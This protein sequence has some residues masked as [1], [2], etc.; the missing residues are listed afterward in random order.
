MSSISQTPSV[1]AIRHIAS[2][3]VYVGSAINPRV[4]WSQHVVALRRG[5]HH[6]KYLQRTWDKYGKDAFVFEILEPV[7]FVEDLITREQYWID[8]ARA[9]EGKYGFNV[10]PTA[11]STLG[12][13]RTDPAYLARLSKRIKDQFADPVYRAKHAKAQKARYADPVQR[14]KLLAQANEYVTS[15]DAR[16]KASERTKIQFSDPEARA[17]AAARTKVQFSDPTARARAAERSRK[18]FSDLAARAQLSEQA[19]REYILRDPQGTIHEVKNLTAFCRDRGLVRRCF[20][21]VMKGERAHHKGWTCYRKD[22][23]DG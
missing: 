2:G 1:Y 9:S 18:Q 7:L 15:L 12:T 19:S 10:S 8:V 5:D 6:S 17:K 14:A 11:G 16:A 23:T 22:R 20:D 13:K 4:R 21:F 3:K